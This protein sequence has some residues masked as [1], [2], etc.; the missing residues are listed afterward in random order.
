MT[1]SS[2]EVNFIARWSSRKAVS[3]VLYEG[4][5]RDSWSWAL[6]ELFGSAGILNPHTMC[7]PSGVISSVGL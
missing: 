5:E 1:S 3:V 6:F 2:S 4:W 7:V